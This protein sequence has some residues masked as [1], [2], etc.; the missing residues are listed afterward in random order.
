MQAGTF[1]AILVAQGS[2]TF[3]IT[4]YCSD[5]DQS[6]AVPPRF[7][8]ADGEGHVV[9]F[10]ERGRAG[11][12][13]PLLIQGQEETTREGQYVLRFD[14]LRCF[15]QDQ[16]YCLTGEH[17]LTLHTGVHTYLHTVLPLDVYFD[18][19]QHKHINKLAA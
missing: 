18:T 1:Q 15:N 19:W 9:V 5:E 12:V 3:L 6:S 2:K 17:P 10:R 16:F 11:V 8:V 7:A 14:S 4:N 13:Q